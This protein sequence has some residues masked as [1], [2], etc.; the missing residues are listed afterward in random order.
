MVR[1]TPGSIIDMMAQQAPYENAA[2]A[3]P[4]VIRH[5]LGLDQPML[6]QYW[7]WLSHFLTGDMG[8]S[9]WSEKVISQEVA[10]RVPIT[11]ELGVLAFIIA[12]LIALPIGVVSA[13]RQ[14]SLLDYMT[15][16]STLLFVAVPV[17]WLGI[18]IVVFPSVWW[19]WSP[20]IQYIPFNRD[21]V[22]NLEQFIIPAIILGISMAALEMR[23][24]RTTVL[25]VLR[26]DYVRTAWA[27]GL[28]ER[29]VIISHVLRNAFVPVITII[30]GQIP[31]M[32]SGSVIIEQIFNLPGM[33]RLFVDSIL[34]RDY[35]IITGMSA[36][37]GLIGMFIILLCDLSYAW[38]DPRI[39]Y[40]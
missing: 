2:S 14:D 11:F 38:L 13:V 24:L 33:G 20:P 3:T 22:G 32:I 12:Q 15:R 5:K 29:K 31:V 39:R 1:L 34:R 23:M 35:P 7:D 40:K 37:F 19:N 28:K 8:K 36:L 17:F 10:V 25:D 27:K 26:Q 6:T 16:G 4:D 21:P 18:M 9:F 30:A